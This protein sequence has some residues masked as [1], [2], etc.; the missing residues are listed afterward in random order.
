MKIETLKISL[1]IWLVGC[2]LF[3]LFE[4]YREDY[5]SALGMAAVCSAT[6]FIL[7]D[8]SKCKY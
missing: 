6:A 8:Y 1:W 4:L 3:G 7:K 5:Y 2:G